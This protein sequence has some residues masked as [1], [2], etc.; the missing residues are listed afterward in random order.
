MI[1]DDDPYIEA[2]QTNMVYYVDDEN[3][4]E[5]SVAIHL[6]PRDLFDMGEVYEDKIYENEPYQQ[7]EFRQFFDVDYGNVQ[8]AIEEHMTE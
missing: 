5:W 8:I 3:D 4:K 2:S 7:Q 1:V 6:K